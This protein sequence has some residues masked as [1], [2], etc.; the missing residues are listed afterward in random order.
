M[1]QTTR[2][3]TFFMCFFPKV[4][5]SYVYGGGGK[6]ISGGA[7]PQKMFTLRAK[8]IPHSAWY[9]YRFYISPLPQ[10]NP[11]YAPANRVF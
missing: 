2:P 11:E 8:T 4:N 5:H 10:Q 9:T 1:V 7:D 3:T 6:I